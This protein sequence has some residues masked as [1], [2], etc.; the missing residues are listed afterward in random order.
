MLCLC[1]DLEF[2]DSL[3][4]NLFKLYLKGNADML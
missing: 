2:V 4:A 3:N 1:H